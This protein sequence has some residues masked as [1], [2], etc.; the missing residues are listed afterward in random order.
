MPDFDPFDL[1]LGLSLGEEI[2]EEERERARLERELEDSLDDFDTSFLHPPKENKTRRTKGK[3]K[4]PPF[5]QYVQNII[6]GRDD[7]N[8]KR[9]FGF[10]IHDVEDIAPLIGNQAFLKD[11]IHIING[12]LVSNEFLELLWQTLG[13]YPNHNVKKIVFNVNGGPVIDGRS[14]FC[15]YNATEKYI[16]FNLRK[17]LANALM[18]A[19]KVNQS[20]SIRMVLWSSMLSSSL[21]EIFHSFEENL[22]PEI[23]RDQLE[24]SANQ[25]AK[26]ELTKLA[27]ALNIE[28][29][30]FEAEKYFCNRFKLYAQ[31]LVDSGEN[32]W[33]ESQKLMIDAN[34]MYYDISTHIAILTAKEFYGVVPP[35][36]QKEPRDPKVAEYFS[37]ADKYAESFFENETLKEQAI[38]EAISKGYKM[39]I[40]INGQQD[41]IV[42]KPVSLFHEGVSCFIN[43][44]E[45]TG[46][47]ESIIDLNDIKNLIFLPI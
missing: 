33:V 16:E 43:Y 20:L 28:P 21:H 11:T 40:S 13:L 8:E 12:S 31:Q 36:R 2:A 3:K 17:H 14:V 24:E 45:I 5:E 26:E 47:K 30:K 18:I 39:K 42:I 41:W 37:Q 23:P 10:D 7:L 6:D 1:A 35:E 19:L 15:I 32:G 25:W 22:D 46:S 34:V 9:V 44:I 27:H 29:P 38:V 4:L